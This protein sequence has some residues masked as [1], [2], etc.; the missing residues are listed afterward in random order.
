MS[1]TPTNWQTGDTVTAEKLNKIENGL[2]E[3]SDT[4]EILIARSE[5][6]VITCTPTA[7]DY[8]G[9]MDVTFEEI[10]AA[11]EAGKKIIFKIQIGNGNFYTADATIT[12]NALGGFRQAMG[13]IIDSNNNIIILAWNDTN[14][15]SNI[16]YTVVYSLTPAS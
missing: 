13:Y 10:K 6:F 7:Q 9:V 5:P 1:Y 2:F 14:E 11:A 8:S 15:N 16:Y 12:Y 3:T 4:T